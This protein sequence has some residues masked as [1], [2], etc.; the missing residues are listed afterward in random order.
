MSE[1]IEAWLAIA[2]RDAP[3]D[4]RAMLRAE[5]LDHFATARAAYTARGLDE[6]AAQAAALADLGDPRATARAL[7]RAFPPPSGPLHSLTR[8]GV[9]LVFA[10]LALVAAWGPL[11]ALGLPPGHDVG[12]LTGLALILQVATLT[13][14]VSLPLLFDDVDLSAGVLVMLGVVLVRA[15]GVVPHSFSPTSGEAVLPQALQS[16]ALA[17]AGI[18]LLHGLL[19]IATRLPAALVTLASGTILAMALMQHPDSRH[20]TLNGEERIVTLAPTMA[21]A[22]TTVVLLALFTLLAAVSW[23]RPS[24]PASTAP[25]AKQRRAELAQGTLLALPLVVALGQTRLAW[26]SPAALLTLALVGLATLGGLYWAFHPDAA[27]VRRRRVGWLTQ[28]A[29]PALLLLLGLD[30]LRTAFEQPFYLPTS[31]V[32]ALLLLLLATPVAL[33][34]A[35]TFRELWVSPGRCWIG[36]ARPTRHAALPRLLALTLSGALATLLGVCIGAQGLRDNTFVHATAFYVLMPLAGVVIGG[37][38]RLSPALRPLGA[39]LGAGAV[40]SLTPLSSDNLD[41]HM[42]A[43]L[44]AGLAV[45]TWRLALPAPRAGATAA[46]VAMDPATE[47]LRQQIQDL[48]CFVRS[49]STTT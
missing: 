8:G 7:R 34:V 44:L 11:A 15:P 37:Q 6:E 4:R 32:W 21:L 14:A 20:L 45:G 23:R 25:T 18:G 29:P 27:G 49:A 26:A 9:P 40:A 43:L 46:G 42:L 38:H 48:P 17:G 36:L 41:A 28:L 22:A 33:A 35:V 1:S 39:I 30:G 12:A 13:L 47:E 16:A 10:A 24:P 5:I 2:L 31:P 19:V 3:A